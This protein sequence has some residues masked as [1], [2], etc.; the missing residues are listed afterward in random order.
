MTVHPPKYLSHILAPVLLPTLLHQLPDIPSHQ[1]QIVPGH[2][3][4]HV[5]LDVQ[6]QPTEKLVIPPLRLD[7]AVDIIL[8]QREYTPI[9]CVHVHPLAAQVVT[10]QYDP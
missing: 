1:S 6:I 3:G 5:V 4:K 7:I 2:G 10:Y 8:S 9:H